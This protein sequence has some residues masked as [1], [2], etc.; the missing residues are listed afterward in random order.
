MDP[1]LSG[2]YLTVDLT[3]IQKNYQILK[4]EVESSE[5]AAV[6]KADAYGLG[7]SEVG[8]ALYRAD[9]RKFFVALPEEGIS[10]RKSLPI[11]AEIFILGGLFIDCEDLYIKERLTP[12]LNSL[13]EIRIWSELAHD[14]GPL[15]ALIHLETGICRLG[16]MAE[17][18]EELKANPHWLDGIEVQYLM[19]HL[20]S[21]DIPASEQNAEQL[22]ELHKL[23]ANLPEGLQHLPV[24]FANSSGIFL[25]KEYHFNLVRPGVALFG[26]NPTPGKANPMNPVVQWQGKIL[27]L[28][29]VDSQKPVGYGATYRTGQKSRIATVAIG[30]ADGY[31]RNLGNKAYCTINNKRVPV[32]GRVS[33][34][35]ITVD[36]TSLEEEDCKRGDLVTLV[37]DDITLDEVAKQ[38]GTIAYEILTSI[39]RRCY[40]RYLTDGV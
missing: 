16:L 12:V 9:C 4:A 27:Q 22:D 29:N 15:P 33:M 17:D 23:I 39:G 25:G 5:C 28:H 2:G 21:A 19:S 31:F 8:N 14:H 26:A 6:I 32:V 40:R 11:D 34:D 18:I 36:V 7:A 24:S 3:A 37:G 10:L 35:M 38:A 20:A 1:R 30:Y 13:D